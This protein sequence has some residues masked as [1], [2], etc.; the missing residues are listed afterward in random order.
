M[1]VF[2]D[3]HLNVGSFVKHRCEYLW[4]VGV[5][6]GKGTGWWEWECSTEEC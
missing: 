5:E 1:E 4:G 3:R 6:E 2:S